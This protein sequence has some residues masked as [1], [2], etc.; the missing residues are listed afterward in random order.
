VFRRVLNAKLRLVSGAWQIWKIEL[1]FILIHSVNR[2]I[3]FGKIKFA[4]I[5]G[6]IKFAKIFGKIKFAKYLCVVLKLKIWQ[7][8]L[9]LVRQ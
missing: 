3:Y 9:L 2:K 1:S 4:K 5:F 7:Q 8:R 6:K